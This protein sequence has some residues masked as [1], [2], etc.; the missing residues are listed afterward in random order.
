[1]W[2]LSL[3]P[4]RP[5]MIPQV[6]S[7]PL[8]FRVAVEKG[9]QFAHFHPALVVALGPDPLL[10]PGLLPPPH[11]WPFVLTGWRGSMGC[12]LD[13]CCVLLTLVVRLCQSV[14]QPTVAA[15][16]SSRLEQ[17]GMIGARTGH[18]SRSPSPCRREAGGKHS[19]AFK[20]E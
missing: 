12:L 15:P 19:R 5:V 11:Q 1:M 14:A 10:L 18:S 2:Q 8:F 4:N 3:T 16:S 6:L 20:E 13:D 17:D 7:A 9:L